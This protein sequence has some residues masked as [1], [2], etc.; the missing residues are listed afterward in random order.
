MILSL[1]EVAVGPDEGL[2]VGVVAAIGGGLR[3]C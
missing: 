2:D 3:R 1:G